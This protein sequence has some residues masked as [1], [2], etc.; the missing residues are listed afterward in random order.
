M[1]PSNDVRAVLAYIPKPTLS[2]IF[3][4]FL[5][6]S[7]AYF[8][9]NIIYNLYLSPLRRYPGP[10]LWA[11]SRIPWHWVNLQGRIGWRLKELHE[12]YGPVVR[13]STDELSYNTSGAW[14][15]IYGQRNPEFLKA[16][17]GR[18]IAPASLQGHRTLL[19]VG[20]EQHADL[21]RA[22]QPAFSD[23]AL[24]EQE[25]YFIY[26]S[27]NLIKQL[28]R[29][30]KEGPVDMG[31]FYHLVAFDIVSDLAFG[32][33]AG[34]L[35]NADQPWLNIIMT[36]RRTI[37]YIQL[38]VY[39]GFF[40]LFQWI[41]PKAA[42]ESRK[43]H[44]ALAMQK[45]KK[46]LQA[47]DSGKDF[48]SYILENGDSRLAEIELMMLAS[49][50]ITAGSATSA[51]TMTG[52]LYLLMRNPAKLALVQDEIRG[53][54]SSQDQITPTSSGACKYLTACL[55]ETLRMYPATPSTLPR[56]VP[57][58]GE[59]IEGSWVPGGTAVGVNQLA[60]GRSERNFRRAL[61]FIPER[62]LPLPPGSEFEN[63]DRAAAQPFSFGP[64]NCIGRAKEIFERN[65]P[66]AAN[67]F[68]FALLLAAIA[69]FVQTLII[70]P[71]IQARK[72][73][74]LRCAAVP[75]EPSRYPLGIDTVLSALRADREQ[76]TPDAARQRFAA[77]GRNTFR[78]S[79]LGTSNLITAEPRNVQALLATQ[80]ADFGMGAARSNN[81]RK[82]LGRSIFAVD[83]H[84]WKMSRA[85]MRPIFARDN[86]A[87]L[88]LL[89]RHVQQLLQCIEASGVNGDGWTMLPVSL[90][91]LMPCLTIDSATAMFLGEGSGTQALPARLA[92][93]GNKG[94][95][96]SSQPPLR[97]FTWAF[98]RLVA[99]LGIR[100]RLRNLYWL[101][102]NHDVAECV[103]ILHAFV[104]DA[105]DAADR[106]ADSDAKQRYNFLEELR[107]RCSDRAEVREQVLGLLAAGRDTTAGLISWVF[108]CLVRH[109]RVWTKLRQVVLDTFGPYTADTNATLA[110]VTFDKLKGCS[111]LQ[112]VLNETL[113]L[114]SIVAFN[115]RRALRDT[116]LPTGGGPDGTQPVFVPAGTE[117]N[118][119]SHVMHLR[120]DLWGKDADEFVP[121][122]WQTARPGWAFVPFNGGPR[123][124]IGQQFALT[125]A[126]YVIVRMLQRY[127]DIA[128]LDVDLTRDYHRFT[129][130]CTPGTPDEDGEAVK[131][132]LRLADYEIQQ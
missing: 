83:G 95:G 67:V 28:L 9:L 117:V 125:E 105:I 10:K 121:E 20:T 12:Q 102:G 16:L 57:E 23:R 3:L 70:R 42:T 129:V 99:V 47:T 127:A 40:D 61:E 114:H 54:F 44:R 59:M 27:D 103:A 60:V 116:T 118:F 34:S 33:P 113:R 5:G 6:L 18:G 37:P 128:G 8:C 31:H 80:F 75:I 82:A 51:G 124:C 63:D 123:I 15:K 26:H 106:A 86:L 91:S 88:A 78:I 62:W 84:A 93:M 35:D 81:L 110:A 74:G 71:V 85:V 111:Y 112:H 90:A 46:R 98:E 89:E 100:M 131:C 50:F 107:Q 36:R 1:A 72:L 92:A 119:S 22:I 48:M 53:M 130:T 109:P 38:A 39:Y 52:L 101:Y 96:P 14:R 21:R 104:D 7:I 2:N 94:R 64:R 69:F 77:M 68:F 29:H 17:D 65:S 126:G 79:V 66:M 43:K 55:E 25:S 13:I 108:Y 87:D 73:R 120:H 122:R 58:N 11:I 115:S 132:R 41:G 4:G 49:T 24:R 30:C 56:F 76:R 45:V 97:D 32:E 19:L